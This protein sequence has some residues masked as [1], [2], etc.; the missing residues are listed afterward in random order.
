MDT[1]LDLRMDRRHLL[2]SAG[3]ALAATVTATDAQAAHPRADTLYAHGAV[4]N[5]DLPGLAGRLKLSFDFRVNLESGTGGGSASDPVHPEGN[6]HFDIT[7]T[8]RER[9]PQGERFRLW[10]VVTDAAMPEIVGLP[11]QIAA[12]TRGQATAVV[13]R[14][15]D[16]VFMGAGLVVI[17][18][19]AIL[20]GLLVPAL[21]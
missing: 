1:T 7:R 17:A 16:Q 3:T 19:I 5:R 11:V 10:G 21:Q 6:L 13:I 20:I 2:A 14:I 12:E 8:E 15:G 9:V 18:I 4:W